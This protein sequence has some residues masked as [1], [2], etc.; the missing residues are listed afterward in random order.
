MAPHCVP[1]TGSVSVSDIS[2][3]VS[4]EWTVTS[5]AVTIVELGLPNG[6]TWMA[7]LGST[8][9]DSQSSSI[10]FEE[11]NGTYYVRIG[12]VAGYGVNQSVG[13]ITV[14][15]APTSLAIAFKVSES[16]A[17]S[18]V[19]WSPTEEYLLLGGLGV[20][21][22][23]TVIGLTLWRRRGNRPPTISTPP[24]LLNGEPPPGAV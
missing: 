11:P 3:N 13:S 14:R 19:G 8:S 24:S 17:A 5:Y 21:A 22:A 23:A 20:L 1:L 4:V 15:A 16:A 2:V 12:S 9:Q 10:L 7:T 6:T 18:S